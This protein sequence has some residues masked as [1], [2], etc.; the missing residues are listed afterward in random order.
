MQVIIPETIKK[1]T[2]L[3]GPVTE[4]T[5]YMQ[6]EFRRSVLEP[7]ARWR[8][9]HELDGSPLLELELAEDTDSVSQRFTKEEFTN[10]AM[11]ERRLN[12][13]WDQMLGKKG[14]R[15]LRRVG[16]LLREMEANGTANGDESGTHS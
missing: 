16:E 9:T 10:R 5:E 15:H 1:D 2:A 13:L 8:V 4:A 3:A 14:E 12:R 6:A 11:M 7:T